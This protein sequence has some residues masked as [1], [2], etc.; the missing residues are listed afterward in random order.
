MK[1]LDRHGRRLRDAARLRRAGDAPGAIDVLA[2]VLT[3]DADHVAA[4]AEMARALRLLD[5]PAGAEEH[6]RRALDVV[7]DYTLICELAAALA[8][9][10]RVAEAEES[11]D[12]ALF[13]TEKQPRL[14]PGEALLVRAVIAH[15][16]GRDDDARAALAKIVPKRARRDTLRYAERVHAS[17][18]ASAASEPPPAGV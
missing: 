6:L 7:L 3:A 16:Q 12:A 15:G 9:Q 17:I 14:D 2:E 18:D 11:L 8:E 1:L 4:N 10:G 13:M 5:D